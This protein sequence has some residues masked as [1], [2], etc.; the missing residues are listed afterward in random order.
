MSCD[1]HAMSCDAH[2]MSCDTHV[3]RYNNV[4]YILYIIARGGSGNG[5]IYI[6]CASHVHPYKQ[7]VCRFPTPIIHLLDT[8]ASFPIPSHDS[9]SYCMSRCVCGGESLEMNLSA[10]HSS[11]KRDTH[12]TVGLF[13][14]DA[15]LILA[16]LGL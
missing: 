7:T 2:A 12:C 10:S 5:P 13:I 1:P 6:T 3:M 8:Y 15:L 11:F 9:A 16:C 4:Y 14:E